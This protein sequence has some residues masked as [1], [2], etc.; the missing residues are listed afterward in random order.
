MVS[1]PKLDFHSISF[2]E[3]DKEDLKISKP[4]HFKFE[5]DLELLK[6]VNESNPK[7]EYSKKDNYLEVQIS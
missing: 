2:P 5:G 4:I 7:K 6:K 3:G 1:K